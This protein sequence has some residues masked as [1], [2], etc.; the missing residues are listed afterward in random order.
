M[1]V[2][3][4]AMADDIGLHTGGQWEP[5]LAFAVTEAY[6]DAYADLDDDELA[7]GA[8]DAAAMYSALELG[9]RLRAVIAADVSRADAAPDPAT[10]PAAVRLA[11]ALET[12]SVACVFLDEED[13]EADAVA[14]HTFARA[15][16]VEEDNQAAERLGERTLLWYDLAEVVQA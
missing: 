3:I 14:A 9:S 1:R 13:A 16:G 4:P 7:D 15:G 11:G 12:D 8:I 6:R 5:G 10:H 2:Y